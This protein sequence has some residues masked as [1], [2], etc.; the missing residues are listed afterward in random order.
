MILALDLGTTSFKAALFTSDLQR[1]GEGE[2]RLTHAYPGPGQ[3]ELPVEEV[4]RALHEAVAGA[5]QRQPVDAIAVTSQAQTFTIIGADGSP[6]MPFISWQDTRTAETLEAVRHTQPWTE[7]HRHGSFFHPIPELQAM[8]LLHRQRT[9]MPLAPDDRVMPLPSYVIALLGGAYVTDDNLAA[10][11]GLFSLRTG[12]WWADALDACGLQQAQLPACKSIGSVVA[13]TS[14]AAAAYGL[15]AGVPIVAAG[16]D[17]TAG[18]VGAELQPGNLL[19]TLGTAFVVYQVLATE[20]DDSAAWAPTAR[21]PYPDGAWYRLSVTTCGGNALFWAAEALGYGDDVAALCE[22]AASA[23]AGSHGVRFDA[24][25]GASGGALHNLGFQHTRAD[26]ARAVVE[27]L[28]I[29]VRDAIDHLAG[30]HA[31]TL[32]VAGGGSKMPGL[33]RVFAE[34]IPHP[35]ILVNAD[36]LLGAARMAARRSY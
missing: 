17:Q 25:L 4:H 30:D 15:P 36:P 5:V 12:T 19:V 31:L 35:T 18:A 14:T 6:R 9:G 2:G 3:V 27:G 34:M 7:M 8:Q 21:G 1:V 26:L 13:H 32:R 23:P 22:V 33:M 29:E 20:P 28:L 10:M 16:N 11:S 24:L